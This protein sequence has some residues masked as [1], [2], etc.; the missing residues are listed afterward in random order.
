[1]PALFF[2]II[3]LLFLAMLFL[4]LWQ[5]ARA[6]RAHVGANPGTRTDGFAAE[7]VVLTG[8]GDPERVRL[9]PQGHVF[10]R[11]E[12]ADIPIDDPYASE[13]HARVGVADN[14]VIVHDLGSTNGTYVN[15][16]RV[17]SPTTVVRGDTVQIGKT[18][19]E[20]R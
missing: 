17:T 13:F 20:V 14:K 10:G 12:D 1:M 15:G 11:S 16:R 8:G 6:V 2:N 4:F 19:L 3:K 18:I 7:V 9:R 5:I